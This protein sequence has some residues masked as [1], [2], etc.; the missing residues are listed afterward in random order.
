M[1]VDLAAVEDSAGSV[2]AVDSPAVAPAGDSDMARMSLDNFAQDMTKALGPRLVS[3]LLYGSAARD[4][5]GA[6]AS[7]MNTLL[8]VDNADRDL[9]AP[10]AAPVRQWAGAGHPPPIILTDREWRDSA[11]AF[12]IE[13]DDIRAAHR[14]VAGRDPWHGIRVDRNDVRRQLEHELMGKLVHL[15]Q[16]YAAEWSKPKRLAEVVRGTWPGFLTML[17]A[18][19]RLAGRPAP[20]TPEAVVRDAA[21]LIGFATDGLTEPL[22][23]LDAMGRTAE[24]VNRLERNPS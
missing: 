21:A 24:Y 5:A 6:D 9:Y 3:L 15:R 23:Y 7:S 20:A 16:V 18:V 19:L 10:L 2:V 4:G 14:V 12:P 22:A 8:I 13:Y 1:A 11:D 17:R